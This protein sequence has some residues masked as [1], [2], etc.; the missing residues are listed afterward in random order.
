MQITAGTQM[1]LLTDGLYSLGKYG[2]IG[3]LLVLAAAITLG[4]WE[5]CHL[6]RFR[7]MFRDDTDERAGVPP[8]DREHRRRRRR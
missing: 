1:L 5:W 7:R 6:R 3:L 8:L 2:L 4:V